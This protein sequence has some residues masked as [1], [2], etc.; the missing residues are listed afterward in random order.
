VF[1]LRVFVQSIAP[2]TKINKHAELYVHCEKKKT[3]EKKEGGTD[4]QLVIR[5]KWVPSPSVSEDSSW[6]VLMYLLFLFL[7]LCHLLFREMMPAALARIGSPLRGYEMV[8]SA[9]P[10][11]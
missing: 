4:L 8:Y 1:F 10:A 11:L 9:G 5:C 2:S 6:K 7:L 3:E